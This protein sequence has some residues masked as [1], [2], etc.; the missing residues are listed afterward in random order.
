[1]PA[2]GLSRSLQVLAQILADGGRRNLSALAQE[3]QLPT[4]SFHRIAASLAG[5]GFLTPTR[6][7]HHV[8][9][10]VMIR[11]Q[12]AIDPYDVLRQIALPHLDALASRT[13]CVAHLGMLDDDMVTYIAKMGRGADA[14]FTRESMQL[15]AYCSALGKILLAHLGAQQRER[16]LC[17]GPFVPLTPRTEVDPG[18]LRSELAHILEQGFAI[19]NQAVLPGLTCVAVPIYWPDGSVHAALS[20]SDSQ[21][22]PSAEQLASRVPA[23]AAAAAEISRRMFGN[24]LIADVA[25]Y[26]DTR[27]S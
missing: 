19:D 26:S 6:R 15:E 22:I 11:L 7:G 13:N 25:R 4:A 20:V 23:L 5:S 2:Y 27:G 14:L 16:Y 18:K 12:R 1:M 10:P 21:G 24:G 9:G 3:A 8:A 17:N